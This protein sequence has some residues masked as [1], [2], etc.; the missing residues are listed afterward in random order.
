MR[1][2]KYLIT[3]VI[4]VILLL[5][6]INVH[7]YDTTTWQNYITY[8]AT[9]II[10]FSILLYI[11]NTAAFRFLKKNIDKDNPVSQIRLVT[12]TLISG[13]ICLLV[14][15]LMRFFYQVILYGKTFDVFLKNED[16]GYYILSLGI[17][18][19]ITIVMYSIHY[20]K[21]TQEH[22]VKQQKNI[23]TKATISFEGLKNQLDP[24]F[25]FNSLNVLSALIEENPEKAQ[26]FTVS[27]SKIYRYVLDQKDKSLITVEEE[28]D[29]AKLYVSLLAMRFENG[30]KVKFPSEE[31]FLSHQMIPLSLQLLLEN[32]IKH[33]IVSDHKPLYIDLFFEEDYLVVRNNH[34]K[35]HTIKQTNGV[36]LRNIS[37]RY[38]L[39]SNANMRIETTEEFFTVRLPLLSPGTEITT[40]NNILEQDIFESAYKR[41]TSVKEFYVSVILFFIIMPLLI[42]INQFTYPKFQWWYISAFFWGFALI[43]TAFQVINP[44]H[45]W[46]KK[47]YKK[48]LNE[49]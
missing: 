10:I 16:Y 8:D 35:K 25:L 33:N 43:I 46:E 30:L 40:F 27:L 34:Q 37:Q 45:K 24:H 3:I 1:N 18:T 22:K 41:M 47:M 42:L 26:Q 48:Y 5:G 14:F 36:G 2:L 13:F 39:V 20:Y 28:L 7:L 29:F 11:L 44:F 6:I 4:C 49:K 19:V 38:Q 23:A 15:F 32:A 21:N 31:K 17:S 9:S 12:G